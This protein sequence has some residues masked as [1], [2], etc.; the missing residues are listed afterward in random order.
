MFFV[1]RYSFVMKRACIVTFI[2]CILLCIL[3]YII[4]NIVTVN[5]TLYLHLK[6]SLFFA[7]LHHHTQDLMRT[8]S[9]NS[10]YWR[11][12]GRDCIN[13]ENERKALTASTELRSVVHTKLYLLRIFRV[14]L[15]IIN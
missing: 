6:P 10:A 11:K 14:G 15:T 5:T 3:Q 13:C 12:V 2:V 8:G 4:D 9:V 7:Y 1:K